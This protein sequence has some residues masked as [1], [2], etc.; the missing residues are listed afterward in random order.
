MR[1][2]KALEAIAETWGSNVPLPARVRRH[3]ER[4]PSCARDRE[5]TE[6]LLRDASRVE[7]PDPGEEY[8]SSL[9]P[10]IRRRISTLPAPEREAA[11]GLTPPLAPFRRAITVPLAAAAMVLIAALIWI[12]G[13]TVSRLEPGE[14]E[15]DALRARFEETARRAPAE[16]RLLLEEIFLPGIGPDLS[17]REPVIDPAEVGDVAQQAAALLSPAAVAALP[18]LDEMLEGLTKEEAQALIEELRPA[19]GPPAGRAPEGDAG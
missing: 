18:D 6:R 16:E 15:V 2:E 3:L 13:P 19:G 10:R 9:V 1:C 17:D 4:C 7:V 11:D 8:W 12:A 5:V 14:A